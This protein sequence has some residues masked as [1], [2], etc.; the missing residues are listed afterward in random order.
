MLVSRPK[1]DTRTTSGI[2]SRNDVERSLYL[3]PLDRLQAKKSQ[4]A[5]PLNRISFLIVNRLRGAS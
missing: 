3:Y 4:G 2:L 5:D 1:N